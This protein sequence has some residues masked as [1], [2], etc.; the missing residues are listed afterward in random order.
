ML[1]SLIDYTRCF[2]HV[3]GSAEGRRLLAAH[4]RP[5]PK[6][7]VSGPVDLVRAMQG[8]ADWLCHA[9]DSNG[10]GGMGSYHLVTGWGR[11]YPET[12]GYIIPTMFALADRLERPELAQRAVQ[13][14]E[15]LLKLQRADGGWQGGRVGEERSS[16]VFNTAQVIRGM[17]A[18][19]QRTKDDRYLRAARRAGDWIVSVQ[20]ADGTWGRSNF[21]GVARVYDS[22]VDAPLLQLF[23]VTGEDLYKQAA[24]RNLEW[25]ITKQQPNGWFAD[26][27]NTIRHNDR[28]IIH[29][30][31]Y[32]IDGLAD[33]A[34]LLNDVG[35]MDHA[36]RAAEPLRDIFL[37]DDRL[38]G[39]YDRNWQGSE[40]LITTGCAQLCIAWEKLAQH[41]E[42]HAYRTAAVRMRML[43][44]ELQ[45]RS[46]EGPVHGRGAVTGSFPF[47]GRYEKF[48]YPNWATK[49]LAD[50]LLWAGGKAP[51]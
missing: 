25:V 30:I 43:L 26:A 49:Y 40:A 32:T 2:A 15:V 36:H 21:M 9:Q 42:A 6:A 34:Y 3:V 10:D 17:L 20:E 18:V 37:R 38:N 5:L 11:T 12:T 35:L 33:C 24:V 28:P 31:A 7:Q 29:T 19:H 45:L 46:S 16:V 8:A 4:R 48:A 1:R 50:A 22:Y 44:V 13:A 51:H 41:T 27:D 47:W 14:A 39:R 23:G